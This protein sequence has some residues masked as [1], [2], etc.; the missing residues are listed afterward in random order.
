[1]I[2]VTFPVV[3]F[4]GTGLLAVV[5][6]VT[7]L[8]AVVFFVGTGLLAV[9]FFVTG[10]LAVVFFVG[11]GLSSSKALKFNESLFSFTQKTSLVRASVP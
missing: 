6:F 10:L 5:F 11:T 9:V 3:F 2:D 4:V 1:V 7:G 8:L